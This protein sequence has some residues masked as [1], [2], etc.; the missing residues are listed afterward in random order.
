MNH[1]ACESKLSSF[2]RSYMHPFPGNWVVIGRGVVYS[3]RAFSAAIKSRQCSS[4]SSNNSDPVVA[5]VDV[6]EAMSSLFDISC[7]LSIT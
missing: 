4:S 5:T 1:V 6:R 7:R 3:A 2:D